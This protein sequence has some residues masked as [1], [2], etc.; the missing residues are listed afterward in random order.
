MAA[1][2]H[3]IEVLDNQSRSR[4]EIWVDGVLAGI[5][6]YEIADDGVITLLH[7]IIDED[8]SRQGYARAMVRGILDGMRARQQQ[9]R[10]LCTYVQRFLTRFPEY[11]DLTAPLP[12]GAAHRVP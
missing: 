8:F 4:Y 6:G 3:S 9:L 7:T 2:E 1:S 10:P 5:E 11:Q 12:E